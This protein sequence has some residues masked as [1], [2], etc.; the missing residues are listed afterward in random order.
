MA[1]IAI[2]GMAVTYRALRSCVPH[3]STGSSK[4]GLGFEARDFNLIGVVWVLLCLWL[5]EVFMFGV[6]QHL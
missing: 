4:H 3:A 6:C 1:N 2:P 5:Q